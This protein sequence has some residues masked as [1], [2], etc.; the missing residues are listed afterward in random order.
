MGL[1][2]GKNGWNSYQPIMYGKSE[3]GAKHSKKNNIKF[4]KTLT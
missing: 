1:S 4:K 3:K 2:E